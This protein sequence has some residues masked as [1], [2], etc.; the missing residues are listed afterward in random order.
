MQPEGPT[1][2]SSKHGA[3]RR[4]SKERELLEALKESAAYDPYTD[5]DVAVEAASQGA[6]AAQQAAQ[7]AGSGDLY[8]V[9]DFFAT[10]GN[11]MVADPLFYLKVLGILVLTVIIVMV[12]AEMIAGS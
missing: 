9:M 11:S 12:A 4:M 7:G 5:A 2:E 1:D 8:A 10:M 6:G 3:R